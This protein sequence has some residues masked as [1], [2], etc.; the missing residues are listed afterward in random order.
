M[1]VAATVKSLDF[2]NNP[3]NIFYLIKHFVLLTN[4]QLLESLRV[5]SEVIV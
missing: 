2:K 1:P 4:T 5:S 3:E